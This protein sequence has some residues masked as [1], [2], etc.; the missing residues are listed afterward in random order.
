MKFKL[1]LVC[2]V[3]AFSWLNIS[4]A[5][6]PLSNLSLPEAVNLTL[7]KN[8]ELLAKQFRLEADNEQVNQAKAK[9][10]P[11]IRLNGSY[12]RGEY[13]I[14]GA[15]G[16]RNTYDRV[17]VSLVQTV[18]SKRN[19]LGVDRA[20]LSSEAA[21]TQFSLDQDTKILELVEVYMDYLKY[22]K[23]FAISNMELDDHV[24]KVERL[25]ALLNRGLATKMDMLEARSTYDILQSQTAQIENDLRIRK[26]RLQRLLGSPVDSVQEINQ[27]LW[28]RSN[29]ILGHRYWLD[30]AYKN[31]PSLLLAKQQE[32]LAHMDIEVAKSGYYPEVA[33]RAEASKSDTLETSIEGSNKIQ[34]ELTWPLYEGGDT[35]SRVKQSRALLESSRYQLQDRKEFLEVKLEETVA[36]MDGN[37]KKIKALNQTIESSRAYL[38][39]AQKGL[40]YG[41]RGVFDVL[42]AKSRVYDARRQLTAEVYDNLLAQF[43]FLYLIGRL[44]SSTVKSYLSEDF[45]VVTL[46]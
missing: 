4:H 26:V 29:D 13:E 37:L 24:V 46:R 12:G 14:N 31:H 22:T 3:L 28:H 38:D 11:N 20:S 1:Q 45:S 30:T 17:S 8:A 40:S 39:A 34:I 32:R 6:V 27:S 36:R 7:S 16:I 23:L 42:E 25:Q 33:L 2:S 44:D 21:N 18:Y 5:E 43:E 10:R 35:D 9:N 19:S 41:L 15:S